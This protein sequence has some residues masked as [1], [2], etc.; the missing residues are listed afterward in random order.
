M[1]DSLCRKRKLADSF[2]PCVYGA[3]M[4]ELFFTRFTAVV[5]SLKEIISQRD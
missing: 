2:I 1:T 3:V 4:I 5:P